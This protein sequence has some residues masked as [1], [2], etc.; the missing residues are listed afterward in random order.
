MASLTGKTNDHPLVKLILRY[1]D[2]FEDRKDKNADISPLN[3]NR[4]YGMFLDVPEDWP[5]VDAISDVVKLAWE[6]SKA[7][8]KTTIIYP[9][10]DIYNTMSSILPNIHF[11]S[12]HEIFVA[13]T[14]TNSDARHLRNIKERLVESGLVIFI[15]ASA[16]VPREVIDQVQGLTEGCLLILA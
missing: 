8:C 13:M 9:S 14:R 1:F 16:S 2:E 10:T 15:G 4:R 7:K 3:F 5:W 6:K 12:W 11:I